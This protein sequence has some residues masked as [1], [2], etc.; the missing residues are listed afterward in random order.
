MADEV[1]LKVFYFQQEVHFVSLNISGSAW[2]HSHAC[3]RGTN[4]HINF[5]ES[6]VVGL[7]ESF[8]LFSSDSSSQCL[9]VFCPVIEHLSSFSDGLQKPTN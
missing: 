7:L 9:L 5:Q 4:L 3:N 1:I 2:K 8:A 6:G